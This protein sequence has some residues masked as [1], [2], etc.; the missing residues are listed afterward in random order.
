MK[1]FQRSSEYAPLKR[2]SIYQGHI[3]QIFQNWLP[4]MCS[5]WDVMLLPPSLTPLTITILSFYKRKAFLSLDL[6]LTIM[7]DLCNSFK[8]THLH[9]IKKKRQF[10]ISICQDLVQKTRKLL[11]NLKH[12]G[13]FKECAGAASRL[14][15]VGWFSGQRELVHRELG[16][17]GWSCCC[18][19]IS[20][21]VPE[22]W[23]WDPKLWTKDWEWS[24]EFASALSISW[25]AESWWTNH[26]S[27]CRESCLSRLGAASE[28]LARTF[29]SHCLLS[30]FTW[31][32]PTAEMNYSLNPVFQ[33]APKMC[34]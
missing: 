24:Q 30:N 31:R 8:K 1:I 6:N 2:I 32:D 15:P 4:R 33:G 34:C 11:R 9:I 27:C 18:C 5:C 20:P 22:N 10:K 13:T 26:G 14:G 21:Q 19:S 12:K 7:H 3:Q 29:L 28:A 17:P 23:T 25:C 16:L